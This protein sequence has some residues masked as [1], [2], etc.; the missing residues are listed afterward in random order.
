[1]QIQLEAPTPQAAMKLYLKI[2][3][4]IYPPTLTESE[5]EILT[6]FA[7]LPAS[8]EHFRFTSKGRSM[9]MKALNKSYTKQNLNN[10]IYSLILKRYLYRTK[11]EDRTIYIA[12][13]ILKAYQQFSS[14]VPQ[15][16][17]I[18]INALRTTLPTK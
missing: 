8:L 15:S 4:T 10:H 3:S 6:A 18:T 14:S 1:M 17:T 9:V 2:L 13:A 5:I 11:D 12:P 16:I 7:S